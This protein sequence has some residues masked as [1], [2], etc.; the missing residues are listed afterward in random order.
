MTVRH[1]RPGTRRL[2]RR[3]QVLFAALGV[4]WIGL[5]AGC[6]SPEEYRA[7]ADD[8]AYSILTE[9]RNALGFVERPFTID[10]APGSLRARLLAGETTDVGPLTLTQC[11]DIAAENSRRFQDQRETLYLSALDLTLE[12]WRF[13]TQFGG[14]LSG[15][16]SGTGSADTAEVGASAGLTRV[17]GTGAK[18]VSDLGLTLARD[19]SHG[20]GWDLTSDLS[21]TI[22]QPLLRGAGERIVKEP[23][24][25]AERNVVYAVR[26]Y[27]R[28][29]RR[30]AI[31]VAGQ[32][33]RLLQQADAVAN[34]ENNYAN[35]QLL[36]AR[37]E[38]LA[39]AGRLSDIQVDQARQ[40]ELRSRNRLI[41]ARQ[42]LR[43]S[44]DQFKL[45]LGL[46]IPIEVALDPGELESLANSDPTD[47]TWEESRVLA[48]ALAERLD[49]KT[50]LDRRD[51]AERKVEVAADA[52][53]AGLGLT[54]KADV[55]SDD[56]RPANIDLEDV[57]WSVALDFDLP[58]ERVA[59]RNAYRESTIALEQRKRDAD[60][61][62]DSIQSDLRAELGDTRTN[63]EAWRIQ[64]N[65]VALAERR[66]ESTR[67]NFDAGR[68]AT[69]DL[70]EAQEALLEA[71][72][73]AT[74]ALID[75]QLAKLALWR[76]LEIIRVE[77]DGIQVDP[78]LEQSLVR[79]EP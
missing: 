16:L 9:R 75:Y 53:R 3:A 38:A 45:F 11:F 31:D 71:Q 14:G 7:Q 44:R 68:A 18:I 2:R 55:S 29:R 51:D 22:T 37:N 43:S 23:L 28:F 30:F 24:T 46:P 8:A 27:E 6:Q 56:G 34:E 39:E 1:R 70:L 79:S 49:L 63:L 57:R 15:L 61:L 25:Q 10:P 32:F 58:I 4:A 19:L 54:T 42:G 41:D 35:L 13:E 20:D 77:S 65:A 40:D 64:K 72:N 12:R 69:R 17:L 66:V 48:I 33:Y 21:M 73:A 26:E 78:A 76:D 50:A 67:L 60:E 36:R 59:E 62:G 5:G 47:I 74:Q 52:L